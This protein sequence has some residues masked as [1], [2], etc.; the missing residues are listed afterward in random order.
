MSICSLYLPICYTQQLVNWLNKSYMY[1]MKIQCTLL[2]ALFQLKYLLFL[3]S[4]FSDLTT[5]G[6]APSFSDLKNEP[7]LSTPLSS[8]IKKLINRCKVVN[9]LMVPFIRVLV[10]SS[11]FS[12]FFVHF[13]SCLPTFFST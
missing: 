3:A 1:F 11:T 9:Y 5:E 4:A 10:I 8:P 13:V 6:L 12:S 7:R 2:Q